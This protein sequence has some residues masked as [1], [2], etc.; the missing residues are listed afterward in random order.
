MKKKRKEGAK[1]FANCKK[2]NKDGSIDY[3]ADTSGLA[4]EEIEALQ[5]KRRS[6]VAHLV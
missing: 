2:K 4:I 1:E 5:N 6:R 3:I